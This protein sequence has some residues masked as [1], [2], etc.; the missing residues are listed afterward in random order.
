MVTDGFQLSLK[1]LG[2]KEET[3]VGPGQRQTNF[4][5]RGDLRW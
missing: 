4:G 5:E 1:F 3:L 2:K